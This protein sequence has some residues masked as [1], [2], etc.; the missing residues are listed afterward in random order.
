MSDEQKQ[1]K[2][3]Q[4]EGKQLLKS[5]RK[6]L[7]KKQGKITSELHADLDT[8]LL[9]LSENLKRE[10]LSTLTLEKIISKAE[11]KFRFHLGYEKK[12]V[13][14]EYVESI[15]F[16]VIIAL[17]IR[18][19]L[20]EA[21][22]IPTGSMIPTLL[23]SDHIFVN[24]FLY[25]IS[26]PFTDIRLFD[27]RQP[28]KGEV[29][30]FEYPK[31]G[32]DE[33]KDFIKRVI[34]AP[35][36]RI[37]LSNNRLII[38]G[39]SVDLK[40]VDE[41]VDCSDNPNSRCKCVIEEETIDGNTHLIQHRTPDADA[42]YECRNNPNW[43]LREKEPGSLFYFGDQSSN[44]EWPEVKIPDDHI[45]VMGDNRDNSSDGRYWGLVP[46]KKLKGKAFITW[47]PPNRMFRIIQ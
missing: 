44:P 4:F 2:K 22:K 19:F 31:E 20:F 34:G 39:E 23:I 16:A 26:I 7:K 42:G 35:G 17:I 33:G 46:L 3:L 15:L 40:P 36:D 37:R 24:K 45:F 5:G 29:V 9:N 30:V 32:E 28:R 6:L 41:S 8:E 25:G 1:R 12:S 21:F 11:E 27:F 38:N 14:R 18:A 10:D 43:P 13:F 47:W